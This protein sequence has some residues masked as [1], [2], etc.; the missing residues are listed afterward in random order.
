MLKVLVAEDQRHKEL[1]VRTMKQVLLD[2]VTL[3][4]VTKTILPLH[5]LENLN[6]AAMQ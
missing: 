6:Q 1:S 4:Q 5:I 3:M 2:M